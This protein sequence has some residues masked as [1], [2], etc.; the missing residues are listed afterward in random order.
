MQECSEHGGA[1]KMWQHRKPGEFWPEKNRTGSLEWESGGR[2][3][4]PD[5]NDPTAAKSMV[6]TINKL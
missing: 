5:L 1:K 4:E 2:K 6:E 3:A